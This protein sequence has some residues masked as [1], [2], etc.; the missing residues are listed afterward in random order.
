MVL[1]PI[2]LSAPPTH[3]MCKLTFQN[4]E[5]KREAIVINK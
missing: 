3:N 4:N 5:I 2:A 1:F